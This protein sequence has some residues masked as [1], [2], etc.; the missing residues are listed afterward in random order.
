MAK[1]LF[2]ATVNDDSSAAQ[3]HTIIDEMISKGNRI[4]QARKDELTRL[5]SLCQDLVMQSEQRGLQILNLTYPV[6][7]EHGSGGEGFA[8]GGVGQAFGTGSAP[9]DDQNTT[10][11]AD[12]GPQTSS[13]SFP[14]DMQAMVD[15]SLMEDIGISSDAFFAIVNQM[16]HLAP[17]P[18]PFPD[19]RP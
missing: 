3:A 18:F 6:E 4:A 13:T 7:S 16:D 8:L 12:G 17:E 2:P 9:S 1:T 15:Y 5:E 10:T 19:D 11:G 14:H